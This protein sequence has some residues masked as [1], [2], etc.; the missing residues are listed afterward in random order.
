MYYRNLYFR[1]KFIHCQV[2]RIYCLTPPQLLATFAFRHEPSG[3][4]H[5]GG[6]GASPYGVF[7]TH[8]RRPTGG[9]E[10]VPNPLPNMHRPGSLVQARI[11]LDGLEGGDVRVWV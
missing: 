8:I 10:R 4:R 1:N 2:W 9:N 6:G 5:L 11:H 7:D 3:Q